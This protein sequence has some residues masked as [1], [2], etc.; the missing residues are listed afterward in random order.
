[1][2]PGGTLPGI[3]L[4]A[5]VLP[6]ASDP[7]G[8]SAGSRDAQPH[9][10]VENAVA[11]ARVTSA[12]LGAAERL[13]RPRCR[14]IVTDFTDSSGRP[15]LATLEATLLTA[16]DYLVGRVWFV[17]G[18]DARQC[19][20][21]AVTVA[22]TA[23][24]DHVV[25]I[26]ARRFAERF[27]AGAADAEIV[28]IHELLH[29]LGLA[30]NPPTSSA[31]THRVTERC[32]GTLTTDRLARRQTTAASLSRSTAGRVALGRWLRKT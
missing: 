5:A 20:A 27:A 31:I 19:H 3:L 23:P 26:C 32:G 1:M 16:A 24:G 7:Q 12:V 29:T 25:R 17:D 30:E 28:I 14:Q 10:R 4:W 22:F 11:R 18:D 15:L 13:G 8:R 21:D 6:I 9:V 2:T